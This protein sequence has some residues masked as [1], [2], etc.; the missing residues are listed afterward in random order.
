MSLCKT[1]LAVNQQPSL[2]PLMNLAQH[3]LISPSLPLQPKYLLDFSPGSVLK[4]AEGVCAYFP[5][6]SVKDYSIFKVTFSLMG[7]YWL[8]NVVLFVLIISCY[9]FLGLQVLRW[10]RK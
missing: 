7:S 9:G 3:A 1:M 4:V 10:I 5:I 6:S 8:F 2:V